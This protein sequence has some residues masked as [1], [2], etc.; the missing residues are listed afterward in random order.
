MVVATPLAIKT[1]FNEWFP[2]LMGFDLKA[3][4]SLARHRSNT[5]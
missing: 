4:P 3:P 1:M 5:A 2:I